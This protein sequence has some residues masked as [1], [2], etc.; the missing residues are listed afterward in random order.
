MIEDHEIKSV[1]GNEKL[2]KH[3]NSCMDIIAFLKITH[4]KLNAAYFLTK[5]S[6]RDPKN[7]SLGL[8]TAYDSLSE[9]LDYLTIDNRAAIDEI[10]IHENQNK[11]YII[12][13]KRVLNSKK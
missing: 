11:D 4:S 3:S 6:A 7:S 8:K 13:L 10:L 1:I 12:N 5:L 2:I 9:S